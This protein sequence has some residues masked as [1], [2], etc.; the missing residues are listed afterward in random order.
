[1][2]DENKENQIQM[3]DNSE[4]TENIPPEAAEGKKQGELLRM[5]PQ[6]PPSRHHL[7]QASKGQC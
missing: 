1:M 4:N 7:W 2:S 3:N 6:I 5:L